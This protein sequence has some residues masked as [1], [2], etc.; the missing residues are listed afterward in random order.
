MAA[1][2][3]ATFEPL[4]LYKGQYF[5]LCLILCVHNHCTTTA[6]TL[7]RDSYKE[8]SFEAICLIQPGAINFRH[9]AFQLHWT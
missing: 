6:I 1:N 8:A 4:M 3:S 5:V 7:G 2:M 9:L